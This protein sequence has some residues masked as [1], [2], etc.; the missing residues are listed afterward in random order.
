MEPLV[1]WTL[2]LI[3]AAIVLFV[4]EVLVPSGG[5]VGALSLC[6]L[7]GAIVCLFF[8]EPTYGWIGIVVAI[9]VIPAAIALGMKVFPSTPIGRRLILHDAQ[10]ADDAIR[11]SSDPRED[12]RDLLGQRGEVVS[13]LRPV[14]T[15]DFGE[16]RRV[17]C[18]GDR[19]VIEA[20]A[21]VEVVSVAGIEVK[22]RPV[23]EA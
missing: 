6:C 2:V 18:L 11:Y 14:G 16:G 5:I 17:E 10:K 7:T 21:T 20:G 22:V 3:V 4:I 23:E 1:T 13:D 8:I 12:T 19:G 9:F 15:V